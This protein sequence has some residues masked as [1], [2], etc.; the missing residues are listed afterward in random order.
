LVAK[1]IEVEEKDKYWE[2]CIERELEINRILTEK[3]PSHFV[4][5]YKSFRKNNQIYFIMEEC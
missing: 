5:F 4:K 3:D 1:V 2:K